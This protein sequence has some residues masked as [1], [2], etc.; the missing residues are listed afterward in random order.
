[1][2]AERLVWCQQTNHHEA[3]CPEKQSC[4]CMSNWVC[5]GSPFELIDVTSPLCSSIT[6][7]QTGPSEIWSR[8]PFD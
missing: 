5:S 6:C 1:M 8:T 3:S 2:V 7:V 4:L